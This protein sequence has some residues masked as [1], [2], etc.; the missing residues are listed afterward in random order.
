M[1]TFAVMSP[2]EVVQL[3]LDAFNANDAEKLVDYYADFATNHQTLGAPLVGREAIKAFYEKVF[4]SGEMMCIPD[5]LFQDGEWAILECY[6]HKG[7]R[8]C[9]VFH[10][11]SGEIVFQRGYGDQLSFL[12]L[13][14]IPHQFQTGS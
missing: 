1:N 6:D 8:S 5:N 11:I 2:K 9:G 3:W 12:K 4:A 10:V 13:H 7:F 14:D